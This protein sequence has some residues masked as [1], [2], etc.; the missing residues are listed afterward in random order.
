MYILYVV[1]LWYMCIF[2]T[3]RMLY[4]YESY[5]CA[6]Y[7]IYFSRAFRFVYINSR[8]FCWCLFVMNEIAYTF[9]EYNTRITLKSE[10]LLLVGCF[11]VQSFWNAMPPTRERDRHTVWERERASNCYLS[12]VFIVIWIKKL[13]RPVALDSSDRT[14]E[15]PIWRAYN[16]LL[17]SQCSWTYFTGYLEKGGGGHLFCISIAST[18][19]ILGF[20]CVSKH[21]N[22]YIVTPIR[23][24]IHLIWK[25]KRMT[26][27]AIGKSSKWNNCKRP[28]PK[29]IELLY[30]FISGSPF[31]YAWYTHSGSILLLLVYVRHICKL[32][33]PIDSRVPRIHH[34]QRQTFTADRKSDRQ[35]YRIHTET[36]RTWANVV[37]SCK[38]RQRIK[39]ILR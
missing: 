3:I 15:V 26:F 4:V 13:R 32:C 23:L 38:S 37:A 24:I 12:L 28:Q 5:K 20:C 8:W 25:L 11:Y 19:I 29:N 31:N 2:C 1:I 39:F 9:N 35:T 22:H 10:Y 30:S 18:L 17:H 16:S 27:D 33:T 36:A 6:Q 14:R 21:S 7:S 34:S